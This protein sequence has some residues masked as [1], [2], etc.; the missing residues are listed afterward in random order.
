MVQQVLQRAL[1][2]DNGLDEEA[3]HGEHGQAPILDL[4]DLKGRKEGGPSGACHLVP[5][6]SASTCT[7]T[8]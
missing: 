1:A 4:L 8:V 7:C 3:E 6:M 2:S 5:P